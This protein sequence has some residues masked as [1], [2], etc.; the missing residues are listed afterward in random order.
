MLPRR[1]TRHPPPH[2]P[3][4]A[5]HATRVARAC[6]LARWDRWRRA[7][8][9]RVG[10][11]TPRPQPPLGA[12]RLRRGFSHRGASRP[13]LRPLA[14]AHAAVRPAHCRRHHRHLRT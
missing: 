2:T 8:A 10:P 13:A 14:A 7:G 4:A 12:S 1:R 11:L 3:P 9:V 6:A 5:A